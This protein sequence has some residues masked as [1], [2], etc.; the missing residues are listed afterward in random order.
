M[1]RSCLTALCTCFLFTVAACGGGSTSDAGGQPP[2]V[3]AV[4]PPSGGMAGGTPLTIVGTGFTNSGIGVT[5]VRIGGVLVEPVVVESSTV[6]TCKT[7]PGSEGPVSVSVTKNAGTGVLPDAYTYYPP[8]TITGISPTEGSRDGGLA[9]TITG[10]G[11]L[12]NQPGV[13]RVTFGTIPATFY[14]VVDDQTI[15][16]VTPEVGFERAVDVEVQNN[17]G[18]AALPLAFTYKGPVPILTGVV[19]DSGSANG[20]SV[21]RQRISWSA[22][23]AAISTRSTNWRYAS[24]WSGGSPQIP[25]GRRAPNRRKP[26]IPSPLW[27]TLK[28]SSPTAATRGSNWWSF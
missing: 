8:P 9:V 3:Q 1:R 14:E 17:N 26:P 15:E 22:A 6:I 12:V 5:E 11:F 28:G 24:S 13:N 19:P 4:T 27:V 21:V 10:S 20:F 2:V 23:R 18:K 16:A 7:P 25:A